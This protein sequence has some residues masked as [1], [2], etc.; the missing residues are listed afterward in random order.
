[1]ESFPKGNSENLNQEPSGSENND[2]GFPEFNKEEAEKNIRAYEAEHGTEQKDIKPEQLCI[3]DKMMEQL[4]QLGVNQEI[5]RN[6]AFEEILT[7]RMWE[8][9]LRFC[10][11]DTI[12]AGKGKNQ[13]S[14]SYTGEHG[15]SSHHDHGDIHAILEEDGT[16]VLEC[17]CVDRER[18]F[19]KNG[20]FKG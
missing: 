19:L 11:P 14:L 17:A 18:A 4:E 7:N 6:P 12:K 8:Y 1:M 2:G 13:L 5:L 16:L 15:D 9:G 3:P 20:S 10:T